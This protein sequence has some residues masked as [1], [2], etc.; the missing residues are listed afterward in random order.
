MPLSGESLK[1]MAR[2]LGSSVY[3]KCSIHQKGRELMVEKLGSVYRGYTDLLAKDTQ[4]EPGSGSGGRAGWL[5]TGRLL[6]RS[7]AP[8]R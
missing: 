2:D 3:T 1:V 5:V 7:P 8:S 4:V 6:V